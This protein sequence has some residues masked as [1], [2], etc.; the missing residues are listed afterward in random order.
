MAMYVYRCEK[1]GGQTKQIRKIAEAD[2]ER[3]CE[4]PVGTTFGIAVGGHVR[5]GKGFHLD[6]VPEGAQADPSA[7]VDLMHPCGGK[8]VREVIQDTAFTPY[9]W[10]P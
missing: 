5:E 8:L 1:C 3:F 10:K 4:Y 7:T 2:D 9:G 6:L